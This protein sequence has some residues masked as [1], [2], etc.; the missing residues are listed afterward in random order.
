MRRRIITFAQSYHLVNNWLNCFCSYKCSLDSAMS[1]QLSRQW[2]QQRLSLIC[3]LSELRCLTAV[4]NHCNTGRCLAPPWRVWSLIHRAAR[5]SRRQRK[6]LYRNREKENTK[7][8]RTH[9]HYYGGVVQPPDAQHTCS[10]FS[11]LLLISG[12]F[13][14]SKKNLR[15]SLR[16]QEKN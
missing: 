2:A 14:F 6:R 13:K 10:F 7:E 9:G 12:K 16:R 8:N 5:E 4:P 15:R 3:G 11:L 1:E